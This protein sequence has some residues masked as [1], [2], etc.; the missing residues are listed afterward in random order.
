[1][2]TGSNRVFIGMLLWG[3]YVFGCGTDFEYV[4]GSQYVLHLRI[5]TPPDQ[6]P[7]VGVASLR[8]SLI[9]SEEEDLVETVDVSTSEIAFPVFARQGVKLR[10]EGLGVD[11][12][13]VISSGQSSSFNMDTESATVV[14]L[15]FARRREFAKLLGGLGYSR[16]GHTATALPNGRV[17]I[18]GGASSG[19]LESPSEFSPPEIYDPRRQ[20]S[21]MRGDETC[22]AFLGSDQRYG[23]TASVVS[24]QGVFIFGGEDEQGRMVEPILLYD[25]E[26][27]KFRELTNYDPQ[28]I[29]FR[30]GHSA[31]R[32]FE[33]GDVENNKR[34]NIKMNE[35][36]FIK[37]HK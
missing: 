32:F 37:I 34:E 6:D 33:Y 2:L 28:Q 22:P 5:H 27:N 20:T 4:P 29:V 1:M 3:L 15:L 26:Q 24:D 36:F 10:L 31:V 19:S 18:F 13:E 17:L 21:C 35:I 8:V 9:L 12:E 25:S 14:E 7:F 16:F 30:T 23:H 11:G